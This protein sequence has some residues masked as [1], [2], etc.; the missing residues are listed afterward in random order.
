ME[1]IIKKKMR[2]S[3]AEGWYIAEPVRIMI[4]ESVVDETTGEFRKVERFQIISNVGERLNAINISLIAENGV[5]EVT[6][7]NKRITGQQEQ[8]PS[9]YQVTAEHF[10]IRGTNISANYVMGKGSPLEC[11]EMFKEWAEVNIQG[12]F[13]VKKIVPLHYTGLVVP[14]EA[15]D[16]SYD[17]FN[18]YGVKYDGDTDESKTTIRKLIVAVDFDSAYSLASQMKRNYGEFYGELSEIKQLNIRR[19]FIDGMNVLKYD[20]KGDLLVK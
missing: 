16:L 19:L 7:S 20:K 4:E 10:D 6:V 11:E 15:E 1:E 5:E 2:V 18:F 12:Q 17:C 14:T 9:L 3:D 8:Y 13:K